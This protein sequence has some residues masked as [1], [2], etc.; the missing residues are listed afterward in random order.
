MRN[1]IAEIKIP[2]A[3]TKQRFV[4]VNGRFHLVEVNYPLYFCFVKLK[5]EQIMK[6]ILFTGIVGLLVNITIS[7]IA[8]GSNYYISTS[9]QVTNF[10]NIKFRNNEIKVVL[11]NGEKQIISLA[12]VKTIKANGKIYDKM[13][14]YKNNK[15][16]NKEL[17]MEL[18]AV[19]DGLKLYK[20]CT[21]INWDDRLNGFNVVDYKMEIYA[22]YKDNKFQSE[23]NDTNYPA[24]FTFFG[25]RYK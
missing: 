2:I 7:A 9:E 23:I 8:T 22:V 19:K 10:K 14:V 25:I 11:E 17:L 3:K 15:P 4:F 20:F 18:I 16:T 5:E 24:M 12:K 6:K 13:P 21:D 1:S